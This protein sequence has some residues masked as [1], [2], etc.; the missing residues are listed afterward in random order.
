MYESVEYPAFNVLAPIKT[1]SPKCAQKWDVHWG[2]CRSARAVS[3]LVNVNNGSGRQTGGS[4]G[5]PE[6]T[7]SAPTRAV[8]DPIRT[9]GASAKDWFDEQLTV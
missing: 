9:V 7:R 1:P 2:C 4:N 5:A 6:F 3:R 8:S